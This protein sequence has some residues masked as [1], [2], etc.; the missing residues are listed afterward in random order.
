MGGPRKFIAI[1]VALL[2]MLGIVSWVGYA[3]FDTF[4]TTTYRVP[5]WTAEDDHALRAVRVRRRVHLAQIP[6]TLNPAKPEDALVGSAGLPW[7]ARAM[8]GPDG[9]GG[10]QLAM[11]QLPTFPRRVAADEPLAVKVEG[12]GIPWNV[13][14]LGEERVRLYE[15]VLPPMRRKLNPDKP[16][17]V[18][19]AE[20]RVPWVRSI[21][22][23]SAVSVQPAEMPRIKAIP[24]PARP[25]AVEIKGAKLPP[26]W[27]GDQQTSVK[28]ESGLP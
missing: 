27:P 13:R 21:A 3:I 16:D 26:V 5:S 10:V 20:P 24:D 4:H 15:A 19:I 9:A 12:A 25:M 28:N 11:G 18:V 2:F 14:P 6:W 17:A 22:S 7:V 8:P 1:S 23:L